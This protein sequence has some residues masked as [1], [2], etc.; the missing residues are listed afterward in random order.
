MDPRGDVPGDD[1]VAKEIGENERRRGERVLSEFGKKDD[2]AEG[3]T[4]CRTLRILL[5]ASSS[6]GVSAS[7]RDRSR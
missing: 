1:P 5:Y 7:G 6:S 3:T 2:T 4:L